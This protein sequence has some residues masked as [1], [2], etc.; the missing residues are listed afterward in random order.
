MKGAV[1]G[2]GRADAAQN[3][4]LYGVHPR[5]RGGRRGLPPICPVIPSPHDCFYVLKDSVFVLLKLALH[6][7]FQRYGISQLSVETSAAGAAKKKF[8]A[9]LVGY[10]HLDFAELHMAEGK[11]YFFVA[12]DRTS[13]WAQAELAAQTTVAVAVAFWERVVAA[14]PYSI[15]PVLTD[16]DLQ[17]AALPHR[18]GPTPHLFAQC[19]TGHGIEHR[20]TQVAH[21]WTNGQVERLNRTLKDATVNQF[22]YETTQQLNEHLQ[23]FLLVYNAAKCLRKQKRLTPHEYICAEYDKSLGVFTQAIAFKF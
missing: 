18:V 12:I 3:L 6:C 4:T 2:L 22:F 1:R 14:V 17:F 23:C 13:T 10:F 21:P 20:R 7:L 16:N 19:C 11:Q 8:K 15:H 5:R 9:F